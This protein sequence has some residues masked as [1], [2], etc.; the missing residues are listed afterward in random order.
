[1]DRDFEIENI[2]EITRKTTKREIMVLDE[3]CIGCDI[4]TGECPVEC[5]ELEM[6]APIHIGDEC[7]YCGKCV[8]VCPSNA[9]LLKEEL[10][11][12]KNDKILF[13]RRVL[14]GKRSGTVIPDHEICQSCGV[15]VNKCPTDA[16]SLEDDKI[17]VDN[18][19]CIL[20]GECEAICP[21][22][23]IRLKLNKTILQYNPLEKD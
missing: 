17:I 2:S 22:D 15:C 1:M 10:F 19:K 13:I 23:A 9:I 12:T 20:C 21:V 6:P 7:V 18:E 8:E 11:D 4:C 16:L 5:I 14:V 3:K